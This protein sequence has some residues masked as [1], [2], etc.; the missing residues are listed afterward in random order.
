M[1]PDDPLNDPLYDRLIDDQDDPLWK[2]VRKEVRE[3]MRQG[4]LPGQQHPM[5][6]ESTSFEEFCAG[7]GVPLP[8][9]R[10]LRRRR[11]QRRR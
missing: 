11:C 10:R 9:Q 5:D 8:Q 7:M 6:P 1:Q 4:A 3:M 2:H